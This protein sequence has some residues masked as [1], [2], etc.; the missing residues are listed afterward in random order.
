MR[1]SGAGR[2]GLGGWPPAAVLLVVV[3]A[4][5]ARAQPQAARAE[6][7][8][9]GSI[10]GQSVVL[11]NFVNSTGALIAADDIARAVQGLGHGDL[12]PVKAQLCTKEQFED[13]AKQPRA[14]DLAR[15]GVVMA[16]SASRGALVHIVIPE[17]SAPSIHYPTWGPA[18]VQRYVQRLR[19]YYAA[20]LALHELQL[21]DMDRPPPGFACRVEATKALLEYAQGGLSHPASD[22]DFA[23]VRRLEKQ[24]PRLAKAVAR[25][26]A[27]GAGQGCAIPPVTAQ[28]LRVD[29]RLAQGG[30]TNP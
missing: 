15:A 9:A 23:L 22:A 2:R 17:A 12:R 13:L 27:G 20:A 25:V 8:C 19:V 7:D 10:D 1:T 26:A 18:D 4:G 6:P 5:L 30:P 14:D 29:G 24:A 11:W 16:V 28:L 3:P 21:L